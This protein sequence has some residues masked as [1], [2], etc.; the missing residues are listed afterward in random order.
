MEI[1]YITLDPTKNITLLVRTTVPRSAQPSVAQLLLRSN[2]DAEQVGF[3][4]SASARG[5][6]ARL[7]MMG[8]EFCGNAAMSLAAL[9]AW[10][11]GLASGDAADIP[12][13]VSGE[14]GILTCHVQMGTECCLGTVD[15]PLPERIREIDVVAGDR[16]LSCPAV[17]FPGIVHCIVPAGAL[18]HPQAEDAVQLLCA[19]LKADAAGILLFDEDALSFS[20]LVYVAAT[21]TSVWERGCGSGSAAIGCY[22]AQRTGAPYTVALR[23]PGGIIEV[24]AGWKDGRV[25]TLTITGEVR[26]GESGSLV[27]PLNGFF[28]QL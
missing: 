11:D 23:Q 7:Q 12:M 16:M 22:L 24:R 19:T 15:M 28:S 14:S 18:T 1:S 26:K 5:A 8:G 4:E 3:L 10:E 27:L 25:D 21:H 9:L 13:E 17:F 20:P 2:P 6:R